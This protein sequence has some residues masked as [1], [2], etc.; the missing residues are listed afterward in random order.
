MRSITAEKLLFWTNFPE[1]IQSVLRVSAEISSS[2]DN[3]SVFD[4]IFHKYYGFD[5][6]DTI[7]WEEHNRRLW[8]S[9]IIEVCICNMMLNWIEL[10]LNWLELN[11]V[12]CTALL[13]KLIVNN[14]YFLV[15]VSFETL[16]IVWST[17]E[18]NNLNK[19]DLTCFMH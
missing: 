12:T 1:A 6:T 2:E 3:N 14:C 16:C 4:L 8:I 19:S 9:L 13:L 18:I 10:A 11:N 7:R 17:V 15:S 5:C